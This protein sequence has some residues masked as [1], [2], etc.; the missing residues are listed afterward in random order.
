MKKFSL[1]SQTSMSTYLQMIVRIED[2]L[3]KY[4]EFFDQTYDG[5]FARY[6]EVEGFDDSEGE[7]LKDELECDEEY[8][9]LSSEFDK[10]F[11]LPWNVTKK[12]HKMFVRSVLRACNNSAIQQLIDEIPVSESYVYSALTIHILTPTNIQFPILIISFVSQIQ[13]GI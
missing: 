6:C 12:R 9:I 11:P 13:F 7:C 8:C 4:Y 3:R 1:P 2:G 5:S 10:G